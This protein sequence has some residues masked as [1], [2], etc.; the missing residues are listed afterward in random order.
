MAFGGVLEFARLWPKP[1]YRSRCIDYRAYNTTDGTTGAG[2]FDDVFYYR[3]GMHVYARERPWGGAG[4]KLAISWD[5]H[6]DS[7]A[8]FQGVYFALCLGQQGGLAPL[9]GEVFAHD[10]AVDAG[11]LG[12]LLDLANLGLLLGCGR[13]GHG[14]GLGEEV[15]EDGVGPQ[16]L[17]VDLDGTLSRGGL[18]R[19]G[20]ADKGRAGLGFL[21]G[22]SCSGCRGACLLLLAEVDGQRG[23][24]GGIVGPVDDH[25]NGR[26]P[27]FQA[28]HAGLPEFPA[29]KVSAAL[30]TQT[31]GSS[32]SL[33]GAILSVIPPL[34][35]F[36]VYP[37]D[38]GGQKRSSRAESYT[39]KL[40][41]QTEDNARAVGSGVRKRG[42]Y[43]LQQE[44][45]KT[46]RSASTST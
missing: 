39:E 30:S 18:R 11:A 7:Y 6:G 3:T 13:D 12:P 2:A 22:S 33:P 34:G 4:K 8:L 32:P 15:L 41:G 38:L 14:A 21:G 46:P 16:A 5:F 25:G 28:R 44:R 9:D 1:K 29:G 26:V 17:D 20:L 10:L 42:G 27:V 23:R 24:A 40:A 45:V 37:R 31:R 36:Q 35:E 43:L 19:L